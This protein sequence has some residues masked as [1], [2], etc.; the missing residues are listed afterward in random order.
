MMPDRDHFRKLIV[1]ILSPEAVS[2]ETFKLSCSLSHNTDNQ[3]RSRELFD[4]Q[5]WNHWW[6]VKYAD[7]RVNVEVIVLQQL[8]HILIDYTISSV[9]NLPE[10]NYATYSRP[11]VPKRPLHYRAESENNRFFTR[12]LKFMH[13]KL[14]I[15]TKNPQRRFVDIFSKP[16]SK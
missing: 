14:K 16:L 5:R 3:T 6:T 7:I 15:L 10:M 2:R 11:T 13:K 12:K 8:L 1:S 9:P 4:C